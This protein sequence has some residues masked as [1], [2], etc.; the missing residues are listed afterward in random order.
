MDRRRTITVSVRDD[1]S[2]QLREFA[3]QLDQ[4]GQSAGKMEKQGSFSKMSQDLFFLAN[5]AR[6][7]YGSFQQVFSTASEWARMGAQAERM[8]YTLRVYAG[9]AEEAERWTRAVHDSMRGT[10]TEGEAAEQA[11]TLMKFGLADSA[12]AAGEFA[13]MLNVVAAAN[14][15]LGGTENALAQIQLTLANMSFL[16]LDQLGL[17]VIQVKERMEELQRAMPGM[18]REAAF[19]EAVI[20]ALMEQA[21]KL[22]EGMANVTIE[23]DRLRAKVRGFKEDIGREINEGFEG[24]SVAA[25]GL[26]DILEKLTEK[27]L[28]VVVNLSSQILGGGA[29]SEEDAQGITNY[30]GFMLNYGMAKAAQGLGLA[31]KDDVR[32][33]AIDYLR[34]AGIA[35]RPSVMTPSGTA[36][37]LDPGLWGGAWTGQRI[38]GGGT[39]LPA[40]RPTGLTD[41]LA[42]AIARRD[43]EMAMQAYEFQRFQSLA[44]GIPQTQYAHLPFGERLGIQMG[45]LPWPMRATTESGGIWG[46]MLTVG[47]E[48]VEERAEKKAGSLERITEAASKLKIEAQ[49]AATSLE[50]LMGIAPTVFDASVYQAGVEALRDYGVDSKKAEEATRYLA[51]MTGEVNVES[52][53]FRLRMQGAAEQLERGTLSTAGYAIQVGILAH[54]IQRGDWDWVGRLLGTPTDEE[55]LRRYVELIERLASGEIKYDDVVQVTGAVREGME[56][57]RLFAFGPEPTPKSETQRTLE[58]MTKMKEVIGGELVPV[59]DLSRQR[60]SGW[61]ES[62][63]KD[64]SR[65]ADEVEHS[66]DRI[67]ARVGWREGG[68]LGDLLTGKGYKMKVT[69]TAAGGEL[70]DQIAEL[71]RQFAEGSFVQ[72]LIDDIKTLEVQSTTSWQVMQ[73]HPVSWRSLATGEVKGFKDDFKRIMDEISGQPWKVTLTFTTT[74]GGVV[75]YRGIG[76]SGGERMLGGH[77]VGEFQH[78]GYTGDGPPWQIAGIVHKGELVISQDML[79]MGRARARMPD[80]PRLGPMVGGGGGG[81]TITGPIHVHGVQKAAQMSDALKREAGRRNKKL[82]EVM[83]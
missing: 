42:I 20:A 62:V 79:R 48:G 63:V 49:K 18:S 16:R 56:K 47:A 55:G 5:N 33:A 57:V 44:A 67:I 81:V 76:E 74:F 36:A 19:Q 75:P 59:I 1:F 11:F 73:G 72:P 15:R 13:R 39:P 22:G 35:G 51:I 83:A 4:A 52:E 14:P 46:R 23:Q 27:P 2:R 45:Q 61:K 28:Y 3:R 50:E 38:L 21:N 78:G 53:I 25:L 77:A 40:S 29:P 6:M 24:A 30:L 65:A 64:F 12:E 26:L 66:V 68:I 37:P 71:Q 17:S 69:R 70:P 82:T 54:E 10:I 80:Y 58:D 31:T 41:Q 43:R 8:S 7:V 32:Q 34:S 9:S 60:I